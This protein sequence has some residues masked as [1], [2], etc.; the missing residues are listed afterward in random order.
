[1]KD[2]NAGK[3]AD[4]DDGEM[5]DEWVRVARILDMDTR[6]QGAGQGKSTNQNGGTTEAREW[7]DHDPATSTL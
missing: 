2:K 4:D 6:E 5:P 7:K 3:C 1:M